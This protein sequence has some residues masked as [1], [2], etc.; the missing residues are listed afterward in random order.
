[1]ARKRKMPTGKLISRT[2][3][4]ERLDV[5]ERTI[6]RYIESHKLPAYRVGSTLIR[7]RESDVETL[8]QRIEKKRRD[9]E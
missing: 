7:L 1:M 6:D 5:S 9:G 8:V 3:A 2:E 4:A